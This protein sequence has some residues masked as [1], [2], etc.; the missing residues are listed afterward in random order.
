VCFTET[1]IKDTNQI[2]LQA[3]KNHGQWFALDS[4]QLDLCRQLEREAGRPL[5]VTVEV[6]SSRFIPKSVQDL[7]IVP[8][9]SINSRPPTVRNHDIVYNAIGTR[10][11]GM[12]MPTGEEPERL[13]DINDGVLRQNHETIRTSFSGNGNTYLFLYLF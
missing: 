2:R 6:V 11:L 4:G 5:K 8:R 13:E 7:M 1:N 9:T 3:V 12:D 10:D